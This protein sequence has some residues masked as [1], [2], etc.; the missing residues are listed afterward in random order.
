MSVFQYITCNI[1]IILNSCE[2]MISMR[3]GWQIHQSTL[4]YCCEWKSCHI[5]AQNA[6]L[7]EETFKNYDHEEW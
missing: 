7:N 5:N 6:E 3:N 1:P 2:P 4:T